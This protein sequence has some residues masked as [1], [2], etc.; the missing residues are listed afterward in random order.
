MFAFTSQEQ[1]ALLFV[2][3]A[4]ALSLALR[5]ALPH[6]E[7]PGLYDYTLT[8][9]LFKALS[10]DTLSREAPLKTNTLQ[11]TGQGKRHPVPT[12]KIT[13]SPRKQ[14]YALNRKPVL[15]PHSI[16]VNTAGVSVLERLPGIGPKTAQ[17]IVNYRKAHGP[18]T[19]AED[20]KKVKRIGP[21]TLQKI[22]PY[23]VLEKKE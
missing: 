23:I 15:T 16:N 8:D 3:A 2:A 21:K 17:A 6:R 20:L 18:F 19:K 13:K 5:W 9:S 11:K 10:A 1:K 4:L 12:V 14:T 7:A 22:A